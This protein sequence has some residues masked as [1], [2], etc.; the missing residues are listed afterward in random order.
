MEN[1]D[2]VG[3]LQRRLARAGVEKA[4]TDAGAVDGDEITIGPVTFDLE[5]TGVSA[6]PRG[7]EFDASDPADDGEGR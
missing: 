5:L 1:E 2:A 3:Y 4:L 7:A 6:V